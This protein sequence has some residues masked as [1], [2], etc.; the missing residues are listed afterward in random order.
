MYESLSLSIQTLHFE[1]FITADQNIRD[2]FNNKIMRMILEQKRVCNCL[3]NMK[4]LALI[5]NLEEM[6]K[7]RSFGLITFV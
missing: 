3:M 4:S 6:E 2:L 5:Q 7:Q 1:S